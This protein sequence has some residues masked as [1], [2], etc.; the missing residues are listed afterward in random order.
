[1]LNAR[2]FVLMLWQR[3][4]QVEL[5]S[6]DV[7]ADSTLSGAAWWIMVFDAASLPAEWKRNPG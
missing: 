6:F 3:A 2:H 5:F 7:A 4:A 1:M